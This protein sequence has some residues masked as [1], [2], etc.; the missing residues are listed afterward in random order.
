MSDDPHDQLLQIRE[1]V[2]E[3]ERT[4]IARRM[5]P[6]RQTRL[7]AGHP[8]AVDHSAA[9]VPAGS[10]AAR[11]A[12]G[13]RVKAAEAALVAQLFAW[14]LD[15]RGDHLPTASPAKFS[16]TI[17]HFPAHIGAST[18]NSSFMVIEKRKRTIGSVELFY[19][20]AEYD[21]W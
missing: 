17:R 19:E 20:I 15:P 21:L 2:T 3:Y 5:R 13:V 6:E 9:R 18:S 11:Q 4:L 8:A 16:R 14:Y 7:R 12:A 10:L 1:A